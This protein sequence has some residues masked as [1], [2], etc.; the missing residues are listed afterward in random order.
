[1]DQE[2]APPP[3]YSAVDP[4]LPPANNSSGN[5]QS[6]PAAVREHVAD[7][8]AAGSSRIVELPPSTTPAI[9]PTN[10]TSAVAYFEERLPSVSDDT[11]GILHHHMT[12]YPRS[13]SKD[14][15]RRP[16]CWAS[17][18]D[19]ITQQDWDTFLRYLFPPHLGL[20]AASQQLHPHVRAEIQRDRKDR[21]QESDEQRRA[22]I[23]AVV[24]EWNQ[25]FFEPRAAGIVSVYIGEADEAPESALCPRCYPAA[26]KATQGSTAPQSQSAERQSPW[27]SNTPSPVPG[28]HAQS[29][30]WPYNPGP[31]GIPPG[32]SPWGTPYGA[33]PG[34]MQPQT[35]PPGAAPW[36][37]PY[38]Y[39]QAQTSGMGPSKGPFGWI[40][41]ITA[42]A[43]KYGERFAEQAQHYGDQISAQAMHY[44][45]QM[46]GH[47]RWVEDQA[48]FSRKYNTYAPGGYAP[49]PPWL[50][51]Q[52]G[53]P[54]AVQ[55]APVELD[56]LTVRPTSTQSA[57]VQTSTYSAPAQ[58][59]TSTQTRS[60]VPAQSLPQ[61]Q[62]S[63][64]P[65]S[66]VQTETRNLD[67]DKDHTATE[68]SRRDSIDSI[69]S[70]GSLSSF[71][72]LSSCSDLDAS[73][74]AKV[75][76]QLQSLNYCHDRVLYDAAVDLRN[77]LDVL[78]LSRREART[79]GR[80]SWGRGQGRQGTQARDHT[81]WGR[82][83]SPEAQQRQDRE[84]K[85][86][87][88]ELRATRKA[89]REV[90]R[91]AREEQHESRRARKKPQRK[92]GK[93]KSVDKGY[94]V[95]KDQVPLDQ[96]LSNL[97][98]SQQQTPHPVRAQ[99]DPAG[100][101][102]QAYSAPVRADTSSVIS[103]A[104]SVHARSSSQ[105][106][107]T[108]PPAEGTDRKSMSGA[109]RLRDKLKSR[110]TKKPQQFSTAEPDSKNGE[111]RSWKKKD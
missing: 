96:R 42:Q 9:V 89:F 40:S 25:C 78:K 103:S 88:E 22:R 41:N 93:N 30:G 107:T 104:S 95:S 68:S 90:V 17:R 74:L 99:T 34:H 94:D 7:L 33:P 70:D 106:S 20:A 56:S 43:Q 37:Y 35:A 45:R 53:A 44:G 3:P 6:T 87:R 98:L 54:P 27:S 83:D 77:Q 102:Y 48:R 58:P 59:Q 24:E 2:E 63:P 105:T 29:P 64:Q 55:T 73:D 92:E 5:A 49:R 4:L 16:R 26:T 46:E 84:K 19:E 12:I 82:W 57:P 18:R 75:R 62:I 81:D 85:A 108:E 67:D 86:M 80:P 47:A 110:S 52:T 39:A 31:Y 91:T 60:S 111:S 109:Q 65:Q 50:P 1:M 10:F 28:Q 71:Q 8:P 72:S 14:F 32:P 36:Q 79:S 100:Y 101:S 23:M 66:L 76:T 61:T 38:P 15:P 21:P 51:A 69:S 13:Q 11:R 97:S